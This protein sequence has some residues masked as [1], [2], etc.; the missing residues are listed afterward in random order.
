MIKKLSY[1]ALLG[2]LPFGFS[3]CTS[4]EVEEPTIQTEFTTSSI[5]PVTGEVVTPLETEALTKIFQLEA[6]MAVARAKDLDV[7]R[8]ETV[9]W[10]A[11]EFLKYADWD[12]A[13][14]KAVNYMF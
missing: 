11:K 2:T 14:P 4:P 6:K 5:V 8:E 3:A 10:F 12:E 13:N 9:V 7:T 1:A